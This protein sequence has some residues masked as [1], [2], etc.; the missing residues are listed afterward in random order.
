M[1]ASTPTFPIP[2]SSF[3]LIQR[4]YPRVVKLST[5]QVGTMIQQEPASIRNAICQKRFAIPHHKNSNV[6]SAQLWFHVLDVAAYL[7]ADR[8]K[9]TRGRPTKAS[10]MAATGGDHA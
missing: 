2:A 6:R 10:K 1:S 8:V 7:D 9:P 3:E 4:F 5:D